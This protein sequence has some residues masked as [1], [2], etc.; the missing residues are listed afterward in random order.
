MQF[1]LPVLNHV[2]QNLSPN[3]MTSSVQVKEWMVPLTQS[4]RS[5]SNLGGELTMQRGMLERPERVGPHVL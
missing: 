1:T 4:R 5:M 2:V 3:L